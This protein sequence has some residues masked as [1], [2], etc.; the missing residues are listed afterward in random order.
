MSM[1]TIRSIP[2]MFV[3]NLIT[4]GIYHFYWVYYITLEAEKFTKRKD[5][6]PALEL[7]LSVMTCNLY[8]IYWYNKYGNIIHKEIALK[9]DENDKDNKTQIVMTA[10]IIVLLVGI[11]IIGILCYVLFFGLLVSTMA[12]VYNDFNFIDFIDN[13]EALLIFLGTI[14]ISFIILFVITASLI[15]PDIIMQKKLNSI[16]E[17]IRSKKYNNKID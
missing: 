10:S 13:P 3:L 6:S 15:I 17:K 14:L 2:A 9:I 5:I 7:L 12:L 16:W 1:G 4:L 8:T 11:P